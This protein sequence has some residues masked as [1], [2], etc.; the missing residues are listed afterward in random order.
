MTIATTIP[1]VDDRVVQVKIIYWGPA[2]CGKTTSLMAVASAFASMSI[3]DVLAVQT[4]TGRTLWNEYGAFRFDIPAGAGT[5]AAIV[6][7][8]ALTG[9]ERFLNTREF[10]GA[11]SDGVIFVADC[12]P[13]LEPPTV[14]SYEELIAFIGATVPVI[15]QANFQD[16]T[17]ALLPDELDNLL[18]KAA[19]K[20]YFKIVPTV[21]SAGV[22]VSA[23]FVELLLRVLCG[24]GH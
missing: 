15:V 1:D 19:G 21:A 8:S 4:T 20:R 23:T 6:H 5:V 17:G 11:S 18:S 3:D 12:R 13:G 22:N 24:G 9:Q 2:E 7:L 10:A 14:R 16:V